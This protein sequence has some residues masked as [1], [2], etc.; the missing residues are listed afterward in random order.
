MQ[1]RRVIKTMLARWPVIALLAIIGAAAGAILAGNF[2][3]G[4]TPRFRAQAPITFFELEEESSSTDTAASARNNDTQTTSTDAEA[5]RSRAGLLLEDTLAANPRLTILAD[6][7]TN[8]LLFVAVGREGEQALDD[9]VA[10]R[11]EYQAKVATVLNSDEITA[12]MATVLSG[13]DQLRAKIGE[14]EV[15]EP[16]PEDAE[17]TAQR[18]TL[19]AQITDLAERQAQIDIWIKNP[20]LRPTEADFYDEDPANESRAATDEGTRAGEGSDEETDE[21]TDEEEEPIISQEALENE[22]SRNEVVLFRLQNE[23]RTV[24][25]PPEAQELSP[26][27][28]LELEALQLDL[29]DL[30]AEYVDLVR[31]LDGRPPGAFPEEPILTNQTDSPRPVLLSSVLGLLV[32]LVIAALVIVGLDQMRKPVW[33]SSDLANV[34]TLALVNR[35][36]ETNEDHPIWYPTALTQRRRDVQT[37]RAATDGTTNEQPTVFGL[38]GVGVSREEVGELAADLAMSYAVGDRNVLLIDGSSFYPNV[39]PEFG[40]GHNTLNEV[41]MSQAR[42]EAAVAQINSFLDHA[43]PSAPRLTAVHVNAGIHDPIDV[44]ASPNARLFVDVVLGRYDMVV[45]AGP[46]ISDPLADAIMRRTL[47]VGLVGYVGVTSKSA[48]ENAA[49]ALADR[50]AEVAGVVLLEGRRTPVGE[51][52]RT[53]LRGSRDEEQPEGEGE[54][55]F[56][57]DLEAADESVEVPPLPSPAESPTGSGRNTRAESEVEASADS[58]FTSSP[59]PAEVA[60]DNPVD[61][62]TEHDGS[63]LEKARAKRA[64]S[65]TR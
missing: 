34:I 29:E 18:T 43:L 35:R 5:E 63:V 4:I 25:D 24:P 61:A 31:G 65:Q 46:D 22:K 59:S 50:K 62:E 57:L 17:I 42:S 8:T 9:A 64:R 13:I 56:D 21:E 44:F 15:G 39:I 26:Q 53:Y 3:E 52:V 32:G 27:Q 60:D 36:R 16:E 54:L 58:A 47:L 20:E 38:F 14:L 51:Q 49:G 10:L 1:L 19:E 28:S 33:A 30:E 37:L 55:E 12:T 11:A 2:N 41:L 6:R 23:L 48:I 45:I 40:E 7:E